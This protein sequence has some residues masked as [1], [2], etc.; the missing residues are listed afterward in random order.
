MLIN[1]N[2][3]EEYSRGWRITDL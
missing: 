1:N 2:W 3:K